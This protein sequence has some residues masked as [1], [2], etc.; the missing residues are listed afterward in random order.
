MKIC[1][2]CKSRKLKKV[3]DLGSHPLCDDLIKINSKKKK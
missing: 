2:V 3:L 1:E